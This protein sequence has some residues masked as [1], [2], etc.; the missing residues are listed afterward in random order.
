V[1]RRQSFNITNVSAWPTALYPQR[2]RVPCPLDVLPQQGGAKKE[3][4]LYA[5]PQTGRAYVTKSRNQPMNLRGG[6]IQ[7]IT[8]ATAPVKTRKKPLYYYYYY[9]II[10][11]WSSLQNIHMSKDHD[12]QHQKKP[13]PYT[14]V[15][16][17][18]SR[19]ILPPNIS[20]K[21]GLMCFIKTYRR[22]VDIMVI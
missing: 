19:K 7:K 4:P 20:R 2:K 5:R 10:I 6:I 21:T 15:Q 22:I 13:I 9:I 18:F 3:Y 17:T 8:R 11:Y 14:N 1:T 12:Y 16:A